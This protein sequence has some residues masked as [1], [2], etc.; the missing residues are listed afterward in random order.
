MK[1][2]PTEFPLPNDIYFGR[3]R[4]APYWGQRLGWVAVGMILAVGI[5]M[6]LGS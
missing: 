2:K 3:N 5:V 6:A 4:P 1:I